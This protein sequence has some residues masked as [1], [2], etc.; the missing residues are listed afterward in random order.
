MRKLLLSLA[1]LLL[2]ASLQAGVG[3]S[4]DLLGGYVVPL[5]PVGDNGFAENYHGSPTG[6]AGL[7]LQGQAWAFGLSYEHLDFWHV[8]V[9]NSTLDADLGLL[10]RRYDFLDEDREGED[11][12]YLL[13]GLGLASVT[14]AT[15]QAQF[16]GSWTG[17]AA[18]LALGY[19]YPLP[20][21]FQAQAELGF[22]DMQRPGSWAPLLGGQLL[23]GLR[24]QL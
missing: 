2:C 16:A 21:G 23:A 7:W 19:A 13:A 22:W 3:M 12:L 9:P 15:P 4:F 17:E 18:M 6:R 20:A 1:A 8:S 10:S 11:H 24:Y 5:G 14:L